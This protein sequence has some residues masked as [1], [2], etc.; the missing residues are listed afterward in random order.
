MWP[1]RLAVTV[2]L[3]ALAGGLAGCGD[4][5]EAAVPV[6][7]SS[8]PPIEQRTFVLAVGRM[9][10]GRGFAITA[11][12]YRWRS[13]EYVALDASIVGRARSL[14]AIERQASSGDFGDAGSNIAAPPAQFVPQGLVDCSARPA[15][16]LYGWARPAARVRLRE[17][18]VA[19]VL[20]RAAAPAALELP[21]GVLVYGAQRG[22]ATVLQAGE[23]AQSL[24]APPARRTCRNATESIMYLVGPSLR[25]ASAGEGP[26]ARK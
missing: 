23:S 17:R 22:T 8:S 15:V 18:G 12:R 20:A 14:G 10:S 19:H 6:R 13:H 11:R 9:P 1:G 16:L 3:G 4:T 25:S 21:R 26:T 2:M 5:R 24:P 7:F